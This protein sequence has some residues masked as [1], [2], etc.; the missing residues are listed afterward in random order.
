M[1]K[2]K[3]NEAEETETLAPAPVKPTKQNELVLNA[4]QASVDGEIRVSPNVIAK[5]ARRATLAVEGVARFYPKT[6][7]DI[8]NIFSARS[9]DSSIAIDFQDGVVNITLSLLFYFG[10]KIQA[11]CKEIQTQ[12][13]E[14]VEAQTGAKIGTITVQVKDLLDPEEKLPEE[15]EVAPVEATPDETETA[16]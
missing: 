2:D 12:V 1:K 16:Q 10:A 6:I 7:S 13:R 9:Y 11:V 5:I 15:P 4:E 3:I 14:Q 8:K